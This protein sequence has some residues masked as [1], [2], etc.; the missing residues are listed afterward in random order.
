M[1]LALLESL[2]V[3]DLRLLALPMLDAIAVSPT[4]TLVKRLVLKILITVWG[5][6]VL[7]KRLNLDY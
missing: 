1:V 6:C 7:L 3:P 2:R 4:T 5:I